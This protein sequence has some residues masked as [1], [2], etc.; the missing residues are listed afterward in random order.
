MDIKYSRFSSIYREAVLHVCKCAQL[1]KHNIGHF[2][3][4][5]NLTGQNFWWLIEIL[6]Q[7]VSQIGFI[8]TEG[9][10]RSICLWIYS[11]AS[12]SHVKGEAKMG[13]NWSKWPGGA[14][15]YN[16]LLDFEHYSICRYLQAFAL[17]LPVSSLVSLREAK[18]RES[19][20]L[21]N[22]RSYL[23]S[24]A[25]TVTTRLRFTFYFQKKR[26]CERLLNIRLQRFKGCDSVLLSTTLVWFFI[27]FF[28]GNQIPVVPS[29]LS[30]KC[31]HT[32]WKVQICLCKNNSICYLFYYFLYANEPPM[33]YIFVPLL[34]CSQQR[35]VFK[36][37]L[38]EIPAKFSTNKNLFEVTSP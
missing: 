8:Q 6:N 15:L 3:P 33:S 4:I 28:L 25:R 19:F 31:T 14:A 27:F 24:H 18:S 32:A 10:V 22:I 17:S 29:V 16:L 11:A 21:S 9:T 7:G 26:R 1:G 5:C 12:L 30:C 23:Q 37:D 2:F 35:M 38:G 20:A 13:R 34:T 36:V